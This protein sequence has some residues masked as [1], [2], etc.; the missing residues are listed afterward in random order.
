[1]PPERCIILS[2]VGFNAAGFIKMTLGGGLDPMLRGWQAVKELGM[3]GA[4]A[5]RWLGIG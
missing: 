1:M 4:Q 5:A 3:S 2:A